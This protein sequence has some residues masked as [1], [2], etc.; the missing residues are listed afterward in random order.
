MSSKWAANITFVSARLQM[1]LVSSQGVDRLQEE[2][3]P[4]AALTV[5]A[6]RVFEKLVSA[7]QVSHCTSSAPQ[8]TCLC[9]DTEA[10]TA[11]LSLGLLLG[12]G[13]LDIMQGVFLSI[14]PAKL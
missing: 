9:D 2:Q 1:S 13:A 12:T 6:V 14:Q 5:D 8:H 10:C 7:A 11:K 3:G 4:G